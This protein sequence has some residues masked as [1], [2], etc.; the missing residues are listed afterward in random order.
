MILRCFDDFLDIFNLENHVVFPTHI[1]GSSLDPV[2]SDLSRHKVKCRPLGFVGSSDHQ[3][4]LTDIK[5]IAE[6]SEETTVINWFWDHADWTSFKDDLAS[7]EWYDI[8]KGDIDQQTE[9]LTRHI[10]DLQH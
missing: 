3:V 1:S 9:I 8:L 6:Q 7:T 4:V 2:V 5:L 10:L